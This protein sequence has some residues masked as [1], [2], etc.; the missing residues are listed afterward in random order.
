MTKRLPLLL[1]GA[2]ILIAS[3]LIFFFRPLMFSGAGRVIIASPD[4]GG[5]RCSLF[6]PCGLAE[7]Q[8]AARTAE[9]NGD[10]LIYLRGGTYAIES[11]WNFNASDSGKAGNWTIYRAYPGETPVLSGGVE[12]GGWEA[13][14]DGIYAATWDGPAFR[15]L[16]A[17]EQRMTRARTPNRENN[18]DMGPYLRPQAWRLSQA[19]IAV[20]TADAEGVPLNAGV[21]MVVA[22][23]WHQYR[24]RPTGFTLDGERTW[25]DFSEPE[26]SEP[27]FGHIA[28]LDAGLKVS[29]DES[30]YWENALEFLDQPGEWYLDQV[31]GR[32]YFLPPEKQDPNKMKV[33]VP[34]TETLLAVNGAERLRF[35]GLTLAYSTWLRPSLKGYVTWQAALMS[36]S[37]ADGAFPGMVYITA[38]QAVELMGCTLRHAGMHGLVTSGATRNLNITSNLFEDLSAG[39]I[40]LDVNAD[41]EGGSRDDR[42]TDNVV[43][44]AG[45]DYS[46]AVGIW[47]SFPNGLVL[48]HND[49]YNLPYSGIS[50]GWRWDP[51]PTAAGNN[52]IQANL[53]HHVL[54][55]M[56]DGGAIYTL[57]RQAGTV[58]RENYIHDLTRSVFAGQYP[59]KG[60]YLDEGSTEIRLV[61]NRIEMP[62]DDTIN[63]HKTQDPIYFDD[64]I[65]GKSDPVE[66]DRV[67]DQAGPRQK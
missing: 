8:A 4:G 23:H 60:I 41:P 24:L 13:G 57:G 27:A 37:G 20:L 1:G 40:M 49:I 66:K 6:A 30:Y 18:T 38:A 43:R 52:L 58:I 48:E 42:I 2:A 11:T 16:Y 55:K 31:V 32:V 50:V 14:V 63:L 15:Q 21:E 3:G 22:S 54:Q 33:I 45:R 59:L 53:I 67:R 25:V 29:T 47:A 56:D 61:K 65:L 19:Q 35:E 64:P 46:D 26:R 34:M 51:R 36:S 28:R 62:L 7:A 12:I 39:G 9:V 10:V 5:E 44:T 17:D